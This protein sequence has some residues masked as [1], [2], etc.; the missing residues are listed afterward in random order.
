M[1]GHSSSSNSSSTLYESVNGV[2]QSSAACCLLP[3]ASCLST[4]VTWPKCSPS[5][6][7]PNLPR[8]PSLSSPAAGLI[9]ARLALGRVT[10]VTA[11]KLLSTADTSDCSDYRAAQSLHYVSPSLDRLCSERAR[12]SHSHN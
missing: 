9:S 3:I 4:S 2:F 7:T 12:H 1:Q 11:A 5:P 10:A 8:P 6:C